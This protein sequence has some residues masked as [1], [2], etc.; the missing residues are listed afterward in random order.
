MLAPLP[1]Q[2]AVD[3]TAGKAR[4]TTA[5]E[6]LLNT[7]IDRLMQELRNGRGTGFEAVALAEEHGVASLRNISLRRGREM[8][9]IP[10]CFQLGW[11]EKVD[12][13]LSIPKGITENGEPHGIVTRHAYGLEPYPGG[14]WIEEWGDR[15]PFDGPGRMNTVLNAVAVTG[16]CFEDGIQESPALDGISEAYGKKVVDLRSIPGVGNFVGAEFRQ[17]ESGLG[18]GVHA[19]EAG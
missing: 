10:S 9:S 5:C 15:V 1:I 18:F 7:E 3:R 11:T 14:V 19:T 17:F 16:H 2:G 12:F 6:P 13:A 4:Q 8:M